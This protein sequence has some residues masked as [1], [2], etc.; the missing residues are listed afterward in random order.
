MMHQ[1]DVEGPMLSLGVESTSRHARSKLY[2]AR[3]MPDLRYGC[4][5]I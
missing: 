2:K 1:E 3:P 5:R 4:S